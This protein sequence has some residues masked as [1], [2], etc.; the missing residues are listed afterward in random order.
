MNW[1]NKGITIGTLVAA[2][3]TLALA[4]DA[5]P[6]PT[7]P[8]KGT[9]NARKQRETARINAGAK[10]G[11]LTKVEAAKLHTEQAR[12]KEE[13]AKDRADGRLT[14]AERAKIARDQNK[15]SR[16]IAKQRHDPQV[17]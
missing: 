10:D 8:P 3:G 17:R 9:I 16:N 7:T 15:L 13:I 12:T 5:V 4:Q 2:L 1:I 14:P 6:S 11:S